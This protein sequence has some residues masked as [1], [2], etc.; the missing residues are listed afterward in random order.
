VKANT[1]TYYGIS[2]LANFLTIY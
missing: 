1:L 2:T